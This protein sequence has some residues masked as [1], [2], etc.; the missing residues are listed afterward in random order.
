[1]IPPAVV[2]CKRMLDVGSKERAG[3]AAIRPKCE[4]ELKDL[5]ES[6]MPR[7]LADPNTETE[8]AV[9]REHC[10]ESKRAGT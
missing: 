8:N 10:S 6:E 9:R 1:M 2:G 5:S 7:P 4:T 3:H